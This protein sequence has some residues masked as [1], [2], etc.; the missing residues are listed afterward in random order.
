MP[1][2]GPPRPRY[3]YQMLVLDELER[4]HVR[5]LFSDAPTLDDDPQARLLTQ[6]QGVVAEYERAKIA[7]RSSS[8]RPSSCAAFS[9][10]T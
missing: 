3:A 2:A 6:I 4:F 10:T 1:V 5:M 7:S 9:T 8:R